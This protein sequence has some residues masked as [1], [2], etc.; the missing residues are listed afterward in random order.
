MTVQ[1]I[2]FA[3]GAEL[4]VIHT[5]K[6]KSNYVSVNFYI[7]IEK[8]RASRVSLL[9]RVL[10]RGT[11]LHP[12]LGELN[13]YTDMLYELSF[14]TSLA[15]VGT[16]QVLRFR[17]DYLADRFIPEDD[18]INIT[19]S[20]MEFMKEYLLRPLIKDGGFLPEY[21]ESE[22]KLLI[23]SINSTINNKD[24]YAM[25]RAKRYFVGDHPS[26][27]FILGDVEDVP[28][29][30]GAAL[31]R[32]FCTILRDVRVEALFVGD[33]EGGVVEKLVAALKEIFAEDRADVALPDIVKP[34]FAAFGPEVR[35][36]TEEVEAK[37]GRMVLCY[38]LSYNG[39][40]SAISSVF[41]EIF[42]GSP[43]SRLF[44][45]VRERLNLCYYCSASVDAT[46]GAMVIRSG[47]AEE[48]LDKAMEEISRQLSDIAAGNVSENELEQAKR[49]IISILKGLKDSGSALGEWYLRRIVIGYPSDVDEMMEK[50]ASVTVSDIA[51]FASRPVL[52]MKYFLRGVSDGTENYGG[53]DGE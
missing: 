5:D 30:D 42:S 31:Y 41:L 51:E 35:E 15:S 13:R 50:V 17:M 11:E 40:E 18:G 47:I 53:D 21:V 9:S 29:I 34:D 22:K 37:Q 16:L 33:T 48:N 38:P 44:M 19:D 20:A 14:G 45:N 39:S 32:E 8:E 7:P 12:T 1:K 2:K 27:I 49:S 52:G 3:P 46:A 28:G 24:T 26:S 23:D 10:S 36:I 43:V 25:L 6:F 4:S